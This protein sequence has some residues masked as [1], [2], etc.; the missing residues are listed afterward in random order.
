MFFVLSGFLIGSIFLKNDFN[1]KIELVKFCINFYIRRW[2]R[3][4]P[5]YYLFLILNIVLVYYGI[6]QGILN[7]NIPAYFIFFQNLYKPLDLFFWESWSLAVE[8][9]FYLILPLIFFCVFILTKKFNKTYFYS[10]IIL[11][12]CPLIIRILNYNPN[13]DQTYYYLYTRKLV[14]YRIDSIAYGLLA[15]YLIKN[16]NNII[17]KNKT[18]LLFIGLSLFICLKIIE[19]DW[20][21]F[22]KQS[23]DMSIEA[24]AISLILFYF[25]FTIPKSKRLIKISTFF[26]IISYSMYLTHLPIIYLM[27]K[28]FLFEHNFINTIVYLCLVIVA[29]VIIYLFWE[30]PTTKIRDK[31]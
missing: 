16:F 24:V 2:F 3:T 11:I 13:A 25:C 19:S 22:Y 5:N 28:F 6:Y 8:E 20:N 9:W 14:I 21:S 29:S 12:L 23:F 31:F 4:L 26:A 1:N 30:N 10:V 17:Y 18:I 27:K 7:N 15:A